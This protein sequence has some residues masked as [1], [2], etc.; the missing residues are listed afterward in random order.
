MDKRARAV[1]TMMDVARSN[2]GEE[3]NAAKQRRAAV[4][5]LTG[6]QQQNQLRPE[7]RQ[8]LGRK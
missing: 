1:D 3:T 4:N 7:V 8:L 6:K 2:R 5:F